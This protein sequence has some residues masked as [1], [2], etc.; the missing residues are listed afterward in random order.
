MKYI[1]NRGDV[2]EE[3]GKSNDEFMH[4]KTKIKY[5]IIRGHVDPMRKKVF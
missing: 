4:K 1:I 5:I 3:L 2:E